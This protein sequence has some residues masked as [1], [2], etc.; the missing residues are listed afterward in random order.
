MAVS[1]FGTGL[2]LFLLLGLLAAV[3]VRG[4]HA[5]SPDPFA[6]DRDA[7]D[8]DFYRKISTIGDAMADAYKRCD[9]EALKLLYAEYHHVLTDYARH[10][11]DEH[12]LPDSPQEKQP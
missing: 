9:Q 7:R 11:R 1:K 12:P 5:P 2:R 4:F 10:F 6:D 3:G 8:E